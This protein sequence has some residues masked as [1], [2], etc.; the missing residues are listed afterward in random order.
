MSAGFTL[1]QNH[2]DRLL[3]DLGLLPVIPRHAVVVITEVG[4]LHE[5]EELLIVRDD[6]QLKVRLLLPCSDDIVE[7]L[8][9]R[10]NVVPIKV[11]RWLVQRDEAAIDPEAL[12]QGQANNDTGKHLLSRAAPT[13]HVHFNV[14]LDHADPVVVCSVAAG[15]ST[16]GAD[17]DRIDIRAL[18]C[19]P[20]KFLDDPIDLFHLNAVK[21]HDCPVRK[22]A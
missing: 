21:F 22:S 6:D 7:G 19:P 2:A 13:S 17:Q 12:G 20:P 10:S 5:L 8:G 18:I 11:C 4:A 9:Q 1:L 16:V 15:R 3:L 14:R